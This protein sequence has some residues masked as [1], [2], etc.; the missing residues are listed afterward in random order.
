Y[1]KIRISSVDRAQGNKLDVVILSTT[2]PG[3]NF[4]LGFV[5][6][7]QHQ[8]VAMTRARDGLVII[9]DVDMVRRKT[10]SGFVAWNEA[11]I[12]LKRE[13]CI[14]SAEPG[15]KPLQKALNIPDP[16]RHDKMEV[17]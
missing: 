4:G 12:H 16:N 6:D 13:Q 7:V 8:C 1:E 3:G 15:S 9:G 17:R 5:A 14:I 10:S 2:R 11:I